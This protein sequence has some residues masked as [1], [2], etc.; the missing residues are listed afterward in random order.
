MKLNNNIKNVGVGP[1]LPSCSDSTL[2]TVNHKSHPGAS[3]WPARKE[4]T[5]IHTRKKRK[6]SGFTLI[7]LLVVITIISLLVAILLPALAAA[8]EAA[9]TLQCASNSRQ[10]GIPMQMYISDHDG[11]YPA[12][13]DA[14]VHTNTGI[15]YYGWKDFWYQRLMYEGYLASTLNYD[16]NQ[17]VPMRYNDVLLCPNWH[18]KASSHNTRSFKIGGAM[19]Y[20]YITYGYNE[21]IGGGSNQN[22]IN[23][24]QRGGN[25]YGPLRVTNLKHSSSTIMVAEAADVNSSGNFNHP[26]AY[27]NVFG[28]NPAGTSSGRMA[29]PY[30]SGGGSNVLWADGHVTTE[31][32]GKIGYPLK[33]YQKLG[34]VWSTGPDSNYLPCSWL[35]K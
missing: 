15:S 14:K 21:V 2:F 11:Y 19:R 1:D 30:H 20:G 28:A 35:V 12:T 10:I 23:T 7:E 33:L 16:Y 9:R 31:S 25:K 13:Q 27:I 17:Y 5:M 29:Y 26:S 18:D 34:L 4:N 3:G 24:H 8:R 6:N 32:N 22:W